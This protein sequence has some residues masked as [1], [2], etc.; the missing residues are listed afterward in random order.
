M[1]FFYAFFGL[2]FLPPGLYL[3]EFAGGGEVVTKQFIKK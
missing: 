2:S 3:M 1:N